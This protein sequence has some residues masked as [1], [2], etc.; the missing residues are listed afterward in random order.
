MWKRENKNY[1]KILD[2]LVRSHSNNPNASSLFGGN[3]IKIEDPKGKKYRVFQTLP[4]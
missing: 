3:S 2:N 4:E 1:L